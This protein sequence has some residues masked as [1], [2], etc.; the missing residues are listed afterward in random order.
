[1]TE[2][3]EQWGPHPRPVDLTINGRD[4]FEDALAEGRG[5][6]VLTGHFGSW[7]V[8]ARVLTG[9]AARSTW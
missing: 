9:S 3:M 6:V 1:M 2:G 8:G 4:L 7:E 5:L